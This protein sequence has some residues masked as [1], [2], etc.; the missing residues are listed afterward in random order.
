MDAQTSSFQSQCE[1]LLTEQ[2][3]LEK[4]AHDVGTDL[5]YYEYLDTA[6]RRLNAP[7]AGRLVDDDAFGEM[8]QNIDSCIEFMNDHVCFR[9]PRF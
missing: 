2:R 7:G 1:D 4:L 5:H 8:I 6:T 9:D 3:R